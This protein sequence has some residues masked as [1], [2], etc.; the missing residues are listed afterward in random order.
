M[1]RVL[2]PFEA[3]NIIGWSDKHHWIQQPEREWES[4][5]ALELLFYLAGNAFSMFHLLPWLCAKVS[6]WGRFLPNT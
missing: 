2:E 3:M 5:E 6:V 1:V 4:T